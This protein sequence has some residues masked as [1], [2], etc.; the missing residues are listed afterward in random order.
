MTVFQLLS[1]LG[2]KGAESGLSLHG[3]IFER[4]GPAF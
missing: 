4:D 1:E 3:E 2:L